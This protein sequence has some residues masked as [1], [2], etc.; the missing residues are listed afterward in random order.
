MTKYIDTE[1]HTKMVII[2]FAP[3]QEVGNPRHSYS[4]S[5]ILC[6]KSQTVHR[7]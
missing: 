6:N 5:S 4:S 2:E 3:D 7:M 1:M